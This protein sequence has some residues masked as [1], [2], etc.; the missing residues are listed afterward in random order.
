LDT[1]NDA[2]R[3]RIRAVLVSYMKENSPLSV[4]KLY[5]RLSPGESGSLETL[6]FSLKTFQRFIA[7]THHVGDEAVAACARF[8][9]RLPGG[10]LET[11][12]VADCLRE[13]YK[14]EPDAISGVY[15]VSTADTPLSELT[16]HPPDSRRSYVVT[17]RSTGKLARVYDGALVF[18]G[19][20]IMALLKDRLIRTA[21]VHMLH[22]NSANKTFYGLVYDDGPLARGALPYQLLQTTLE[23][24]RHAE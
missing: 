4:E 18:T 1:F 21:R 20:G 23:R 6:R 9:E 11:H 10:R 5:K 22:L 14:R 19:T 13:F 15:R 16:I 17:E 8:A 12:R 2:E 3:A 24:I 7:G